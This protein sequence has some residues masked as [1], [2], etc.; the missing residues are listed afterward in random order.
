VVVGVNAFK[1]TEDPEDVAV[2]RVPL[3]LEEA[4][5]ER[6]RA[7]R[8][9]RDEAEVGRALER[10]A[11]AAKGADNLMPYVVEAVRAYATVGEIT[12]TLRRVFGTYV[13]PEF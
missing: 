6:L 4:Q 10:L 12:Q 7:L 8:A 13:P 1:G 9:R 5:I 2:H 3:E 11:V